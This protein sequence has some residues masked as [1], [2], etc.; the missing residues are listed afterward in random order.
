MA[1]GRTVFLAVRYTILASFRVAMGYM[2]YHDDANSTWHPS[3]PAL[4]K[5]DLIQFLLDKRLQMIGYI[6]LIGI[7]K[8]TAN[9]SCGH[10]GLRNIIFTLMLHDAVKMISQPYFLNTF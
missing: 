4:C 10:K 1:F 9:I 6:C 8:I 2:S 3:S 5:L 7:F